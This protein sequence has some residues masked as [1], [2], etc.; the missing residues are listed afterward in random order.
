MNYF[1]AIPKKSKYI[2]KESYVEFH[3][4]CTGI[5][6]SKQNTLNIFKKG[7]TALV[8]EWN[9]NISQCKQDQNQRNLVEITKTPFQKILNRILD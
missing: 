4:S 2:K 7:V 1:K 3:L 8:I 6:L 5:F 9:L